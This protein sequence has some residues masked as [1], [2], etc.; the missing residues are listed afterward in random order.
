MADAKQTGTN[1]QDSAPGVN[2]GASSDAAAKVPYKPQGRMTMLI[3]LALLVLVAVVVAVAKPE[4]TSREGSPS[5]VAPDAQA[6][7]SSPSTT[8]EVAG[9]GPA[10]QAPSYG[11]PGGVGQTEVYSAPGKTIGGSDDAPGREGPN[12]ASEV[13]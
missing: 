10:G 1:A 2:D 3:V 11:Q 8:P 13:R 12:S 4:G 9:G 5:A 6:V 7:A